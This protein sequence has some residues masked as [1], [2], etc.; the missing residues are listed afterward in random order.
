MCSRGSLDSRDVITP[1]DVSPRIDTIE[2]L[3]I[4]IDPRANVEL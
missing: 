1:T 4:A 2:L 3:P